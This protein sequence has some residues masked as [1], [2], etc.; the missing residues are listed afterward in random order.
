MRLLTLAALFL[1]VSGPSAPA[2]S[3]RSVPSP[4]ADVHV[5][6]RIS[7]IPPKVS[8]DWWVNARAW[9]LP[10][11]GYTL[12]KPQTMSLPGHP[13]GL[14]IAFVDLTG[15]SAGGRVRI[16]RWRESGLQV[17]AG[18]PLYANTVSL[19]RAHQNVY[20]VLFQH[21]TRNDYYADRII[22]ISAAGWRATR[23]PRAWWALIARYHRALVHAATVRDKAADYAFMAA[24]ALSMEP[25][26]SRAAARFLAAAGSRGVPPRA[27]LGSL[28]ETTHN[29]RAGREKGGWAPLVGLP[30]TYSPR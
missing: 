6:Y 19:L 26:A 28:G 25:P 14:V 24:A 4:R 10:M 23:S 16:L 7:G 13:G 20:L 21:Y 9:H 2:A 18:P 30:A 29:A 17:N 3:C 22:R 1:L 5:C 15:I 11:S 27:F 8:A 12:T